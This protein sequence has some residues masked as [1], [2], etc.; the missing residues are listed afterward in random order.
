MRNKTYKMSFL[1]LIIT[2]INH[3]KRPH[4]QF[5]RTLTHFKRYERCLET[6]KPALAPQ[7]KKN[8]IEV[9]KFATKNG[10]YSTH[11]NTKTNTFSTTHA[12]NTLKTPPNTSTNKNSLRTQN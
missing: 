11:K 7:I 2:C 5:Q 6:I 9:N 12:W 3:S 4:I 8:A 1:I 10:C